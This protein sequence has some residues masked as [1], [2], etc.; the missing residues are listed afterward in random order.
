MAQ[1]GQFEFSQP[2]LEERSLTPPAPALIAD[3]LMSLVEARCGTTRK[4]WGGVPE[5]TPRSDCRLA[6]A[7]PQRR[8]VPC[9]ALA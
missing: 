6:P 9:G 8:K 7:C 2:N 3:V 4:T 1:F 5:G